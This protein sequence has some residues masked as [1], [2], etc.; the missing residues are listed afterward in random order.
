MRYNPTAIPRVNEAIIE[1]NFT[2]GK[3]ITATHTST[4]E[5]R[6]NTGASIEGSFDMKSFML[7]TNWLSLSPL[8]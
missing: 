7:S 6:L 1:N 3:K 2:L 8:F 5:I 4:I